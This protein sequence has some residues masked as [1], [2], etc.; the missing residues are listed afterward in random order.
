MKIDRIMRFVKQLTTVAFRY[1]K[2]HNSRR[3]QQTLY[4]KCKHAVAH[5]RKI[6]N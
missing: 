5:L 2:D 1:A 3:T 4:C 6:K